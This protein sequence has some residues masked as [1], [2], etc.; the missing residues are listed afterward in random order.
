MRFIL[1]TLLLVTTAAL[2]ATA[3][4]TDGP[5]K[6]PLPTQVPEPGMAGLFGAS[7]LGLLYARRRNRKHL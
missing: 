3:H 4:A 6:D 5:P 7:V 2:P 1:A